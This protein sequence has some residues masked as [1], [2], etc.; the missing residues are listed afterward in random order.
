MRRLTVLMLLCA[1]AALGLAACGS[2]NNDKTS[3]S[4]TTGTTGASSGGSSTLKVSADPSG[5]LKYQ[6]SSLTA[7][8]GKVKVEFTNKSPVPHDV[9]IAKGNTKL[10]VTQV[11]TSGTS[12]TTVNLKAGTYN[13]FCTVDG[14]KQAG[15]SGTL[16]VK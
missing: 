3:S 6:Q 15:M 5:A 10:G 4:A 2:S 8:A 7:K 9:A 11:T 13:Y 12:S 14:H 16:T 1:L